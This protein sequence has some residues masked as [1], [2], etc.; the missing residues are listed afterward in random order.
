MP[1]ICADRTTGWFSIA[2]TLRS[3]IRIVVLYCS[4]LSSTSD[5]WFGFI[6]NCRNFV[7]STSGRSST[8]LISSIKRGWLP[9]SRR[10]N[11][12]VGINDWSR[13]DGKLDTLSL[14]DVSTSPALLSARTV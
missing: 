11:L 2:F 4:V 13:I 14:E 8:P 5:I 9:C 12:S 10:R 6:S 3:G 1:S 7:K